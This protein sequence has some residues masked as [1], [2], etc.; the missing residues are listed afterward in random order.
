VAL[1]EAEQLAERMAE[2]DELLGQLQHDEAGRLRRALEL[3]LP[4]LRTNAGAIQ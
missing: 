1:D 4:E 2:E 3:V